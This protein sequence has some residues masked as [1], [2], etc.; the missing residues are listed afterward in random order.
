VLH[1]VLIFCEP[2]LWIWLI[3]ASLTLLLVHMKHVSVA[4]PMRS[5]RLMH[6]EDARALLRSRSG[7]LARMSQL[8]YRFGISRLGLLSWNWLYRF[9]LIDNWCCLRLRCSIV[10]WWE[11]SSDIL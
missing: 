4:D 3:H 11:I 10:N 6:L 8:R 5:Q 7:N 9:A 2:K 1:R